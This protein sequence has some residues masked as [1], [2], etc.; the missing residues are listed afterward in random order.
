MTTKR[1][2]KDDY[3]H[4]EFSW[5]GKSD[6]LRKHSVPARRNSTTDMA[7]PMLWDKMKNLYQLKELILILE[8]P[9]QNYVWHLLTNHC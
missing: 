1:K 2:W 9:F 5:I 7:R 4:F 3:V 8:Q 6:D